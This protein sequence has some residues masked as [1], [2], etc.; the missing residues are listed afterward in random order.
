[1][2]KQNLRV[3]RAEFEVLTVLKDECF[4]RTGKLRRNKALRKALAT[5]LRFEGHKFLD[6]LADD[7]IV[8]N[9]IIEMEEVEVLDEN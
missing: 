4:T 2:P 5:S 8:D 9:A 7:E 1:M 3:M 6:S